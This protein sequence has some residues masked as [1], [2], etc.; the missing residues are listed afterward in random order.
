MANQDVGQLCDGCCGVVQQVRI[1]DGGQCGQE[2]TGLPCAFLH[3]F[4]CT[5]MQWLRHQRLGLV[6]Q[7][8]LNANP[9]DN[10][11]S[12]ALQS[13]F[14]NLGQ[15]AKAYAERFG[16]RPSDTLAQTRRRMG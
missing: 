15:F 5:P 14:V 8:L 1:A 9:Q 4:G 7:H 11:S 2:F 3:R 10:V 12:L 6:R 13:G 16:E